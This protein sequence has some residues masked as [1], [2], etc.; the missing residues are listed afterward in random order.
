MKVNVS[1]ENW[2][3]DHCNTELE[4]EAIEYNGEYYCDTECLHD[5]I[6]FYIEQVSNESYYKEI[7]VKPCNDLIGIEKITKELQKDVLI[8][9]IEQ[10]YNNRPI[11]S[12]L[13]LEDNLY[14][15]TNSYYVL[16]LDTE[17]IDYSGIPK[18]TD[19]KEAKYPN[20]K[21]QMGSIVERT[22]INHKFNIDDLINL[23][24][25]DNGNEYIDLVIKDYKYR[26]NTEHLINLL[27]FIGEDVEVSCE[28][29]M[30]HVIFKS[31]NDKSYGLL[32]QY[33]SDV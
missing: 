17:L 28:E 6:D 26:F 22:Y 23:M 12:S 10:T 30:K 1:K 20:L 5:Y 8:K 14:I 3:C 7:V 2:K 21:K 24:N 33:R 15:Y 18:S 9:I 32:M 25:N 31:K 19:F 16:A 29:Y 11:L 4:E 27:I 13:H